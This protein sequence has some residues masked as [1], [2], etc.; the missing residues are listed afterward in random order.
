MFFALS[1]CC[2]KISLLWFSRRLVGKARSGAYR[3]YLAAL[4]TLAALVL[5]A[6]V[7][8]VFVI[9]LGCRYVETSHHTRVKT[10]H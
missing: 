2:S 3:L 7:V 1:I 9:L 4:A 6:V 8:F 5:A 10:N